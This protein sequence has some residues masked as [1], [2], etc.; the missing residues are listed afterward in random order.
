MLF[1]T[2]NGYGLLMSMV[3][4]KTILCGYH[5]YQA[6]WEPHVGGA[7]SSYKN[8]TWLSLETPIEKV[9]LTSKEW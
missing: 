2:K 3:M 1:L 6:V 4:V 8:L 7:F 5:A 9:H